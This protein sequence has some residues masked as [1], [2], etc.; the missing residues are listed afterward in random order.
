MV[1]GLVSWLRTKTVQQP[2]IVAS[3]VIGAIGMFMSF[4]SLIKKDYIY[5]TCTVIEQ[6]LF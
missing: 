6:L 4:S 3:F 5:S 1:A 2:V